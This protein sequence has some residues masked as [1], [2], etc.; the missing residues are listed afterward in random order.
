[1][2]II[3]DK[4]VS[5]GLKFCATNITSPAQ[6]I[7]G[8]SSADI[9]IVGLNPKSPIGSVEQ[10]TVSDF[11]QLDPDCHSY[12]RDF[13][14][15]SSKFYTNW[16]S[17]SSRIAHTDLVK[18]FS[19]TFPPEN[20]DAEIII[21][22][23]Q[24]YLLQQLQQYQPKIVICNGSPVCRIIKS[25]FP[26]ITQDIGNIDIT[27]SYQATMT[28]NN[29]QTHI[30]WIVLSG[31]IGRIDDMNKRRL[32]KEIEEICKQENIVL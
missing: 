30:F 25:W 8:S 13:K 19:S 21:E 5:E 6:Y 28:L 2:N 10:R 9:W 18:C 31:F 4:C 27:T 26:P 14:K 11:T 22:N 12:F 17:H 7:E 3:C 32:G 16:K 23:C 20:A 29:G 15:V 1:M 24:S